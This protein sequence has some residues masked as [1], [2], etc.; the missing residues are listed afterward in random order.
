MTKF[1]VRLAVA[2]IDSVDRN[3]VGVD[4]ERDREQPL[5]SAVVIG[6]R[7]L[8]TLT[9]AVPDAQDF[10]AHIPQRGTR[11]VSVVHR[12]SPWAVLELVVEPGSSDNELDLTYLPISI[13]AKVGLG[14]VVWTIGNAFNA[15]LDDGYAAISRGVVSGFYDIPATQP[16]VRDRRGQVVSTYA[17]P[18]WEV[19]A[20]IND[21]SQGGALVN[22]QGEFIG[23]MSLTMDQNRKLGCVI[24]VITMFTE[25]PRCY[26]GSDQ[27]TQFS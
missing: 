5:P 25:L 26:H 14:N 6:P 4:G 22:E 24:P 21:G 16:P 1:E 20:A 9:E 3:T 12:A 18:V 23:M 11:R 27:S 2:A 8:L 7:H 15:V 13:S 17:G 19:D 10:L